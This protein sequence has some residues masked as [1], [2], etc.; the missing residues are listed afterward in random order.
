MRILVVGGGGREH[1]LGWAL[2]PHASELFIAPGNAGTTALGQNVPI[3]PGDID[4]LVHFGLQENIDLTVV[5]PEVSLVHGIAD[6]FDASRLPIV[7]P[8]SLASE[9]EGSKVFSKAFMARHDVP[10]AA[11]RSYAADQYAEAWAYV[12][13]QGVPIVIK[14]SGLAA[15]KGAIVC[16]TLGEAED[17]LCRMMQTR[18][19]GAA[20]DEVIIESYMEGEEASIFAVTDGDDY[21]LLSPAQDH[22]RIGEGDTGLNTGGMGAYAPA[23]VITPSLLEKV[24]GAIIEPTLEGLAREGRIYKGFLYAGIMVTAEGPRVVEFNCRLGDPEAQVLLPLLDVNLAETLQYVAHGKLGNHRVALHSGA[25]ACVVMA[26]GGYPGAY[27]KGFPVSGLEGAAELADTMVFHAGTQ[28]GAKGQTMTAGGR[29]LGVTA[30][31]S[32]L[33]H[34]LEKAYEAVGLI[35]FEGAYYRRDIGHRGLARVG[36]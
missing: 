13:E 26:S 7:G 12:Q 36:T 17:A 28:L 4:A 22:K 31:G 35:H 20:G 8:S 16:M 25:A 32:S 23:P 11:W 27:E 9:I 33:E 30:R 15:G 1:A 29:V 18:E 19:F 5:G 21:V 14:T 24:C 34:A 2:A 10:T 6:A 3:D